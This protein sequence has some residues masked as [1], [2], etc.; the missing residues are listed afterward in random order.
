MF[1]KNGKCKVN[2][3]VFGEIAIIFIIGTILISVLSGIAFFSNSRANI[4][5]QKLKQ[6][7]DILDDFVPYLERY[8]SF[9][10]LCEYMLDNA[11]TL[12]I[13]YDKNEKTNEKHKELVYRHPGM[14]LTE[15]TEEEFK[16]L[17]PED[18]RLFAEVVYNR[19]QMR[20]ND[21]IR[22]YDVS[23]IYLAIANDNYDNAVFIF[24]GSDGKA[25]R[26]NKYGDAYII[27]TPATINEDQ[28][29]A[30]LDAKNDEYKL[31]NSTGFIDRYEFLDKIKNGELFAGIS[32]TYSDVRQ[33]IIES[34]IRGTGSVITFMIFFSIICLVFVHFWISN[35]IREVQKSVEAYEE[36]KDSAE[37]ERRLSGFDMV[38][39][40]GALSRSFTQMAKAIDEYIDEVQTITKEKE[41]IGAELSVASRIQEDMLP[42]IFPPFPERKE[43]DVYASMKPAKEVGGDFYDFFLIDDEH[44]ALVMADVSG[45]GVPAAL[46]MVIAK[47]LIKTRALAGGTPSQILYDVNNQLTEGNDADF[48][49]TVWLAILN[50]R[51]GKG[52]A[53]NAGHEHPIIRRS[54]GE[55][56]PVIYK[57]SMPIGM[58]ENIKFEEHEFE[59][60]KGDTL[61]VYTDGVAE[62]TNVSKELFGMERTTDALNKCK[63]NEPKDIINTVI[64]EIKDFVGS[65][66]QFDDITMLTFCYRGDN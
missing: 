20:A 43:F 9:Y 18:Q 23:Y 53:S 57:H 5:S 27:G 13:E 21:I 39:E 65:A 54:G 42:R 47:T 26:G 52:L 51:T 16:E 28:K 15:V 45:K 14:V 38:N 6:T 34:A 63:V 4:L 1:S 19:F 32:L 35:P 41:R 64:N 55:F 59:M 33:E 60:S 58:L 3:T 7:D 10:Y 30:L 50:V 62:A 11:D 12:D 48:F 46:F 17:P 56:A 29:Q 22:A 44:I 8:K 25:P 36:N 61:F 49:V 37:I 2:I 24:S 66:E 40:F 31:A